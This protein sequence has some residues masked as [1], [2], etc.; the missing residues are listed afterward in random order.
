M[1]RVVVT[2]LADA[3]ALV[4]QVTAPLR[5]RGWLGAETVIVLIGDGAEWIGHRAPLF[6]HRCEILDFWHARA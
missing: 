3:D 5:E 6:V 2:G 4:R 1:R